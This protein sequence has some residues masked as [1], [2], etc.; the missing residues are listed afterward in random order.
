[1][2]PIIRV[3]GLT[4]QY[5]LYERKPGLWGSVSTLFSRRHR[6]VRAV[7][8]ISFNV[9]PGARV[10]YLGP[11]GA[12]KSTTIK[13][14]AG[15]VTPTS[16]RCEVAGV[17]PYRERVRNAANIGVVFGQRSQ[18]WWDLP[19]ADSFAILRRIYAISPAVYDKNMRL[20][21]ELLD[22]DQLAAVPVR[23]LS[24][25]QRMRVEIAASFLHDPRV[26]FLDEPTIGLDAILKQAIRTL[27]R[28]MNEEVGTTIVLTSHDM[29]D[30]SEI[31]DDLILIDKSRVVY[32]GTVAALNSMEQRR[33]VLFDYR[34][35][36]AAAEAL[37]RL[38]QHF[39]AIDA[40]TPQAQGRARIDFR[41]DAL[42]LPALIAHLFRQFDIVDFYSL[43]P[44]LEEI[45]R[46]VYQAG[47][48][49][50]RAA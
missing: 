44:D 30:V 23:K 34:P 46:G 14:L 36:P 18:L 37:A 41:R 39:P 29:D 15:I 4:K 11:N 6:I 45:I 49:N 3:E 22:I 19:V 20:F 32:Q 9:A 38:A 2:A 5:K 48:P 33:S 25:G 12:G 8:N 17:V 16:G 42:D 28:R 47:M 10:A 26:V 43:A 40:V 24:L 35:A 21:R 27:I 7:D 31:C 1:M 13:I 50:Q